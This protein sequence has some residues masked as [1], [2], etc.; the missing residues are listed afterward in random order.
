MRSFFNFLITCLSLLASLQSSI[1]P[2]PLEI[3]MRDGKIL[4]ADLYLP[5]ADAKDLP[6]LLLRSPPGK[7]N[8]YALMFLNLVK[9]GYA[10][11]IQDTRSKLDSEGRTLPYLSDGWGELQDGYDTVAY[12]KK[13]PYTN[14]TIGTLGASA[15]GITQLMMA[16]TSPPGLKAQYIAF[17]ASDL[18]H[19][20]IYQAGELFKHQ[21]ETW[22]GLYASHEDVYKL[23]CTECEYNP[24][25]EQFNM[26]PHAYKCTTPAL[27]IGGWYDT[28]LKGTLESFSTI[29]N[30][31]AVGAKGEQ[32]LVV[33]PWVHLWPYVQ[34]FGEFS[35]HPNVMKYPYP[36]T[37]DYW[38][39]YHLKGIKNGVENLPPV[40]YYVMGPIDGGSSSGNIWKT[41]N[42]WP[43]PHKELVLYLTSS[44]SLLNEVPERGEH[45][46]VYDPEHPS[47]TLGGRNL[48]LPSGPYDQ[49]AIEKRSDVVIY[50][51]APLEQ[52]L[53]VTGYLKAKLYVDSDKEDTAFS[54]RLT[55]LY[56]DGKSVL[57]S[58]GVARLSHAKKVSKVITA[59]YPIE[60][61]LWATSQVFAKGHQLRI[62]VTSSN[63]PRFEKNFNTVKRAHEKP[64]PQ[65]A[66][67]KIFT[68]T[69]QASHLI[70]PVASP[71]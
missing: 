46:F 35:Y 37:P 27:H 16:P 21:V 33:G 9:E 64:D 24:F 43:P 29:Q 47:P 17:A 6:C 45:L 13:S 12:L 53:E 10:I 28:F 69:N 62:I 71:N 61:D 8:P 32:K 63:Y 34:T 20:G 44:N 58:D 66:E 14:G 23:V 26:L 1:D 5:R 40:L 31:G 22:L 48:F 55:D 39:A 19:Q 36:I 57:I 3:P 18:Y 4:P 52:D 41:S 56:P 25:W 65:I 67:N 59:P 54:V 49:R 15:M 68:G 11:V 60:I 7:S 50:T 70:L 51:S 38:F 30:E 42:Q 2:I